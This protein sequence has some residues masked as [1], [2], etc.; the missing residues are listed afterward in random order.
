MSWT[1]HDG[2]PVYW[3]APEFWNPRT[4]IVRL[5]LPGEDPHLLPIDT[6]IQRSIEFLKLQGDPRYVKDPA[7][8]AR[9]RRMMRERLGTDTPW[10]DIEPRNAVCPAGKPQPCEGDKDKAGPVCPF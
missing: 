10:R 6:R 3:L 8:R 1:Q 7:E 5:V 9:M 2:Q 4:G